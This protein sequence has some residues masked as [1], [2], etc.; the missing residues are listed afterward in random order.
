MLYSYSYLSLEDKTKIVEG[1]R[2]ANEQLMDVVTDEGSHPVVVCIIGESFIKAH[3]SLYG[4]GLTTNPRLE[5]EKDSGRLFVFTDVLT[6][7]P[8]TNK[9]MEHFFSL[10]GANDTTTLASYPL[11]PAVF[12]KAGWKVALVDNQEVR[13]EQF[14]SWDH[15]CMY[16]FNPIEI[17][18]QCLDYR[19][20]KRGGKDLDMVL[21]HFRHLLHEPRSL[22]IIHLLGQHFNA[23]DY[24]PSGTGQWDYF[25]AADIDRPDLSESERQMVA[26]YD[27]CTR[28]NDNVVA[29]I[30]DQFRNDEAIVVYFSDHGEQIF[31]DDK[32]LYA[33]NIARINPSVARSIYEIPFIIWVS[34]RYRA[35]HPQVVELIGQA[36]HR[37]F[38][39]DE[40]CWLLFDLAGITFKGCQ[41]ER[42][43]I[44]PRY[45][46]RERVLHNNDERYSYDRHLKQIRGVRLLTPRKKSK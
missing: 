22:N 3:S 26:E 35:A 6:P 10:K 23:K 7:F 43:V 13:A 4:Y 2:L 34:D 27:N 12:K 11:F 19:N 16:F 29:T 41:H 37:P 15:T 36:L 38:S 42:S 8:R 1:I 30:I 14:D 46:P 5:Q 28:Y 18:K 17:E 25:H 31:D 33:R 40:T 20:A 9:T 24:Y 39:N 32:H 45:V 21:G 44:N